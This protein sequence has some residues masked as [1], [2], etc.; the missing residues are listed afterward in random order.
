MHKMVHDFPS[1]VPKS[2]NVL[3]GIQG[4]TTTT[5]HTKRKTQ[6]KTKHTKY[7]TNKHIQANT[8][9]QKHNLT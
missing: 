3:T 1:P 9:P 4:V 6:N 8:F 5:K 7:S 2:H